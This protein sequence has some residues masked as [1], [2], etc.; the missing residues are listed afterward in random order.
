LNKSKK[1][2]YIEEELFYGVCIQEN[3]I[4]LKVSK[5]KMYKDMLILPSVEPI[6]ENFLGSFKHSYTKYKL[7]VNLYRAENL[8]Q[9]VSWIELSE[10][11]NAPISSLTK[12]AQKFF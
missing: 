2:T 9:E 3:K 7:T 5:E 6:E 10:L 8:S 1:T 4:A 11:K 12:K